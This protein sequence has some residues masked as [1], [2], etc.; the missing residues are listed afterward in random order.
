MYFLKIFQLKIAHYDLDYNSKLINKIYPKK[1]EKTVI[2]ILVTIKYILFL[3]IND[4][5]D[6]I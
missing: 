5:K 6:E 4:D 1:Q 3:Y 2:N